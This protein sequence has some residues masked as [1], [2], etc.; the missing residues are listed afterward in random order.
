MILYKGA[1]LDGPAV[2]SADDVKT[3]AIDAQSGSIDDIINA[4][5]SGRLAES[6][7]FI[8]SA[9]AQKVLEDDLAATQTNASDRE[10]YGDIKH[11][12]DIKERLEALRQHGLTNDND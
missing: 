8:R 5:M 10:S 4:I 12:N 7:Q 9:L 6:D 2:V 1:N 3:I 11:Q